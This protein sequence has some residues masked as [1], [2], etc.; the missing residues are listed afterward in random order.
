METSKKLLILGIVSLILCFP[1]GYFA[2]KQEPYCGVVI[3]KYSTS[4]GSTHKS[5]T[6]FHHNDYIGFKH[7]GG[8]EKKSVDYNSYMTHEVG[9][10]IC[11]DRLKYPCYN[12][13]IFCIISMGAFIGLL[14]YWIE[15]ELE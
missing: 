4:E 7:S 8:Y 14:G 1:S 13:F 9:D 11:F 10:R 3:A 15:K 12:V 2:F 5:S 6:T